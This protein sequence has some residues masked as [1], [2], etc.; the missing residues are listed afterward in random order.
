[1]PGL[2]DTTA[3]KAV[4]S[5]FGWDELGLPDKKVYSVLG[6]KSSDEKYSSKTFYEMFN[7]D[8]TIKLMTHEWTRLAAINRGKLPVHPVIKGD[9]WPEKVCRELIDRA[10]DL[11]LT[12]YVFQRTDAFID[13]EKL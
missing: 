4:T 6:L 12:G 10:D 5:L 1:M 8:L 13:R 3:I 2:D 7:P 9:V 11:D